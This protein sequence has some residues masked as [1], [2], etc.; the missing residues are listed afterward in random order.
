MEC[1]ESN[2]E[3]YLSRNYL[4]PALKA[5]RIMNDRDITLKLLESCKNLL[6]V[7][8]GASE[9]L[10]EFDMADVIRKEAREAITLA[11]Q[12]GYRV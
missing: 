6:Y 12:A 3:R 10:K 8:D 9:L 7:V 1:S 2:G 4:V 5:D 11:E